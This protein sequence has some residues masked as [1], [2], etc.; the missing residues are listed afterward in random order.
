MELFR[1]VGK[2]DT[3]PTSPELCGELSLE[4]WISRPQEPL[5]PSKT[6]HTCTSFLWRNRSD[7]VPAPNPRG[8]L[9]LSSVEG[10]FYRRSSADPGRGFAITK[11]NGIRLVWRRSL[12]SNLI[13]SKRDKL[14]SGEPRWRGRRHRHTDGGGAGVEVVDGAGGGGGESGVAASFFVSRSQSERKD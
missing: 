8:Q 6:R 5:A 2:T 11:Q 13:R 14:R 12:V 10:R 4:A 7:V 1:K 9:I 3:G